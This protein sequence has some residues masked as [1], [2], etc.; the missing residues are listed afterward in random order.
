MEVTDHGGLSGDCVVLIEVIDVNE[1]PSGA[2]YYNGSVY[3]TAPVGHRIL[4]LGLQDPEGKN[5]TFS[6]ITSSVD[7]DKFGISDDQVLYVNKATSIS[8][9]S[10][11][12]LSIE[13]S[14]G[15]NRM[16]LL[17]SL[18]VL[19]DPPPIQCLGKEQTVSVSENAVGA[20]VG[21]V[22]FL[23][24]L[25]S[26][27]GYALQDSLVPFT[28][29]ATTGEVIVN[30]LLPLDYERQSSYSLTFAIYY[31]S[32]NYIICPMVIRVLDVDEPPTCT[33]QSAS[34]RENLVGYDKW[35]LQSGATDPEGGHL[36]F[37]MNSNALF[38]SNT[39]GTV[40][41]RDLSL[42]NYEEQS[43]CALV[44]SVSDGVNTVQCS[45]IIYIIDTN[46]CPQIP[47]QIRYIHEN[48]AVGTFVG[49]SITVRDED[50]SLHSNGRI[51]FSVDSDIFAIDKISGT[52]VV[53]NS[54]KLDYEMLQQV[55]LVVYA[56]DDAAEP[57][58]SNAAVT[59]FI[60]DVN[61]PPSIMAGQVGSVLEFTK[62]L[63]QDPSVAVL[64]VTAHDP[65]KDD[66]LSFSLLSSNISYLFR[67][68]YGTGRIYVTDTSAFD[69]ETRSVYYLDLTVTD[70][71]GLS[72]TQQVEIRVVDTNE[73]PGF[74]LFSGSINE[75]SPEHTAILNPSD[76]IAVDPEGE[77]VT[78][79]INGTAAALPFDIKDNQLVVSRAQLDY[80]VLA[81]YTM[82]IQACDSR[83][84]CSFASFQITVNDVNEPP[85]IFPA[86]I[87]TEENAV[88]GA[89]V[90]SPILASDPDRGQR[91]IYSI[92]DGDTYDLFGI[93]SCNGQVYVKRS[94]SLD[95]ERSSTY[96][97]VVAVSDSGLPSLTSTATLTIRICDVNEAPVFTTDYSIRLETK[98]VSID[99]TSSLTGVNLA[100]MIQSASQPTGFCSGTLDSVASFSNQVVC[101]GGSQAEYGAMIK[102]KFL[103]Q[104]DSNVAFRILASVVIN[105]VFLIDQAIY[106]PQS[107][108]RPGF[109]LQYGDEVTAER[110][111]RGVHS[112]V[113]F[114]YSPSDSP[115]SFE[116]QIN[117]DGW[118]TVSVKTFDGLVSE[119]I[120][121][122][123]P[124]NSAPGTAVGDA[125]QAIDEDEDSKL[126]YSIVQQNSPGLFI[127]EKQSGQ[128][129]LNQNKSLDFEIESSYSLLIQVTDSELTNQE[130]VLVKVMDVNEPPI[131]SSPQVF[132]VRENSKAYTPIGSPLSPIDPEGVA[133]N[134]TFE[135]ISARE[136]VPFELSS[137]SGQFFVAANGNIDYE[138]RAHYGLQVK[139]TDIDGLTA[140]IDVI[141]NVIDVNEPP[142]VFI[143]VFSLMEN[144]PQGTIVAHVQGSDPENQ[145]LAFTYASTFAG[146]ANNT[147]F[148]VIQT[149]TS[150]AQI[151]VRGAKIDFEQQRSFEMSV[152]VTD[153]SDNCLSVSQ[154]FTVVVI[155]I[156]E[157][158][159]LTV[160]PP[161]SMSIP[162]NTANGSL[163]GT[164]INSYFSDQDTGDSIAIKLVSSVP[165]NGAFSVSSS[166]QLS[167]QNSVLLDFEALTMVQI[168]CQASDNGGNVVAFLVN[169]GIT[170]VNEA[171]YFPE[172]LVRINIPESSTIGTEV[173]RV[174]ALDPDGNG[175]DLRY[176]IVSGNS[177]Q[178]F[179]LNDLGVLKT[180]R[181]LNALEVFNI[182][183]DAVD[184]F[185]SGLQSQ[186]NQLLM[187]SVSSVN[188]PP[189]V[190]NFVFRVDEN[191]EIG[192]KIG[193][194]W[195]VDSYDGSV[196]SFFTVPETDRIQF[197]PV[198][199]NTSDVYIW[200]PT[201]SF[202]AEPSITFLLCA[203]DDGARND[204][205][206][207]M[208]GC[209]NL[210]VLVVDVN[211]SPK[212]DTS[213]RSA[214]QIT[215][216]AQLDDG[217][218]GNLH[219]MTPG[220]K[221]FGN[222]SHDL[223]FD[224]TYDF[225][226]GD[227][228]FSVAMSVR[229]Q[230]NGGNILHLLGSRDNDYFDVSIGGD[231]KL[232]VTSSSFLIQGQQV[233]L[234][235]AW[236]YVAIV[237]TISD[238]TLSI[239]VDGRLDTAAVV[240]MGS[241][242]IAQ[243]A[244]LSSYPAMFTGWISRFHFFSGAISLAEVQ[245]LTSYSVP[246][247]YVVANS[248]VT[249]KEGSEYCASQGLRLCDL[250]DV[251]SVCI[252]PHYSPATFPTA[253]QGSIRVPPCSNSAMK[254]E[255]NAGNAQLACCSQYS[256][257]KLIGNLTRPILRTDALTASSF[258]Y[259]SKTHGYGHEGL[260]VLRS[261]NV[262]GSWCPRSDSSSEWV[263]ISFPKA[264]IVSRIEV[265][266][267]VDYNGNMGYLKIFQREQLSH[268]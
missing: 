267:G 110:L 81:Q 59:V 20:T 182:S 92:V 203:M 108:F 38:Y 202:E 189:V 105:A 26:P 226:F 230:A 200:S 169:V 214:R 241:P 74:K 46:D 3:Q 137:T 150:S 83:G 90:G 156:N 6:I 234:G 256:D 159:Q 232:N 218:G 263:Q 86:Q 19:A 201:L 161:I 123:I 94:D 238:H 28:L 125:L 69:F 23:P 254:A 253:S 133:G 163:V 10:Q 252:D 176:H 112:V 36:T 51:T 139:I 98:N 8:A 61:E 166:S 91:L 255:L 14:D 121:R 24:S 164:A 40:F 212:F 172:S 93:Q 50:Y 193:Q 168:S 72:S 85:V 191:I 158:P 18:S 96:Q 4:K 62:A 259:N 215:E 53:A 109:D 43:Y 179:V 73:P 261:D 120:E 160:K 127:I 5:L 27:S 56:T 213:A 245:E 186:T 260:S 82:T 211:E 106:S 145:T 130:W 104:A 221:F 103:L 2:T 89:L 148:R 67:I 228:D 265:N 235:G 262:D 65:D 149:S 183:V 107:L 116:L 117:S 47:R 119:T 180:T 244:V 100:T 178:G 151:E 32:A 34:V 41:A 250:M 25:Y 173:H 225:A 167:V 165:V 205:V 229:T 258:L 114:L 101:P 142:V 115:V 246:S 29:N 63:S 77:N 75:N 33:A 68:E 78:Y 143:S 21:R 248:G 251:E 88:E 70:M 192:T 147:A 266:R 184:T 7:Q 52:L 146:D 60:I 66:T 162:E 219:Y 49:D 171:P 113:V 204:Y 249:Q 48:S 216:I 257:S 174:T 175:A 111:H 84:L 135:I 227:L 188:S 196:L 16:E 222:N 223:L 264:T 237:S 224:G 236:H 194:V 79:R 102:W 31:S 44:L 124:E 220:G 17:C 126:Y 240:F 128:L 138:A 118:N 99:P 9:S 57:C 87:S 37:T 170:N 239:Y 134:Y 131:L 12:V 1:P 153:T 181:K 80:E 76:V 95:F 207:A 144:T 190:V 132:S 208:K 129:V 30:D 268:G 11:V 55:D 243:Q 242:V 22:Q 15:Y 152:T 157:P 45:I 247:F 97:I 198:S 13:V 199:R 187:I 195:G 54:S 71:G 141:I 231:G 140:T 217:V 136:S 197:R 185:G 154:T 209:A 233:L 35:M 155:D 177:K 122:S 39:S 64:N 58:S 210:T 206:A 42:V